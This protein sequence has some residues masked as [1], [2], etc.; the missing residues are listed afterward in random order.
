MY[1]DASEWARIPMSAPPTGPLMLIR[2]SVV[3]SQMGGASRPAFG[4]PRGGV[5]GYV[6]ENPMVVGLS[7][8]PRAC[9]GRSS[10]AH[11]P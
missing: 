8:W 6:S 1:E 11:P 4:N 2:S 3:M 5:P 9:S 7:A 10:A